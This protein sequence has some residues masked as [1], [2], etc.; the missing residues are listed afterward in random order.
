VDERVDERPRFISGPVWDVGKVAEDMVGE[1]L[2]LRIFL[3]V[4]HVEE[5]FHD[6]SR[7]ERNERRAL[8]V[9]K[10]GV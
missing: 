5:L 2:K 4:H 6:S 9:R 10:A 7:E 1:R 8:V 3:D